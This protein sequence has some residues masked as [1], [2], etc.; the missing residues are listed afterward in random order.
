M[1]L[2]KNHKKWVAPE[3]KDSYKECTA[4][5]LNY[6]NTTTIDE[7][8]ENIKEATQTAIEKFCPKKVKEQKLNQ[9]TKLLMKQ[10]RDMEDKS[11]QEY[12]TLNR[13]I[14]KEIRKHRRQQDTE[15]IRNVIEKNQSLKVMRNSTMGRKEIQKIKDMHGNIVTHKQEILHSTKLFYQEL[16]TSKQQ[17]I[18]TDIRKVINQGSEEIPE[19][20]EEEIISALI[21]MKNNRAAGDDGLVIESIKEGGPE[22]IKALNVLF[23]KCIEEEITPS[24]WNNATIIIVHKKGDVTDLKNYRPISLLIHVYKLF[25]KI[26]TK[27]LTNKIDI[28]LSSEQAGF[29]SGYGTN[30]H[31]LTVK[32]LIEKCIEYNRPLMLVFVDFEKA[33]D[34]V[35][36][37]KLLETLSESRIDHR[38]SS[39]IRHRYDNVTTNVRIST[40]QCT[41]KFNIDRG[42]ATLSKE[43]SSNV[44]YQSWPMHWTLKTDIIR[45]LQVAQ[46][47]MERNMLGTGDNQERP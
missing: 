39:I 34:S 3:N 12:R 13:E 46:H 28:F 33:F 14:S 40:N 19:I 20:I 7:I 29:R 15:K 38:Y 47:L 36:Q 21:D 8:Y 25:T 26:L 44:Y 11:T 17:G 22:I 24:Q 27:R 31:L 30:Y 5:N 23:N 35:D 6:E 41:D 4:S 37:W 16:Y 45:K 42:N 32:V 9:R 1:I 10:R 18:K 2:K 43:H